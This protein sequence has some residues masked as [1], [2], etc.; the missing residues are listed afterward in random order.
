MPYNFFQ[1]PFGTRQATDT[2]NAYLKQVNTLMTNRPQ[3]VIPQAA[4]NAFNLAQKD[5]NSD[6][7]GYTQTKEDILS[8]TAQGIKDVGKLSNSVSGA[9]GGAADIYGKQLKSMAGLDVAQEQ[10]KSQKQ[11]EL[12]GA[13]EKMADWQQQ[14][15]NWNVLSKYGEQFNWLSALMQGANAD[16]QQ[17]YQNMFGMINSVIGAAGNAAKIFATTPAT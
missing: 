4:T 12:I 13:N 17:G 5:A 15:Q 8:T 6:M 2:Q 14:Q 3:D 1:D 9:I 7:P 11:Q 10:Y 16:K